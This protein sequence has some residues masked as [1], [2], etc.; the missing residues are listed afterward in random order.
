LVVTLAQDLPFH[1]LDWAGFERL[2]FRLASVEDEV[3]DWQRYGRSGQAQEGIDIYARRVGGRYIA[4][5]CKRYVSLTAADVA[6]AVELFAK[7]T[8]LER[9]E[10]LILAT[11]ARSDDTAVQNAVE[12]AAQMLLPHGVAPVLLGPDRLSAKLKELPEIVAV[13]HL[14]DRALFQWQVDHDE[15]QRQLTGDGEVRDIEFAH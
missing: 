15:G 12:A 3:E 6:R 9:S 14:F 1:E 10:R 2:V 5:Q 8:W 7:G 4:W 13:F 11:S